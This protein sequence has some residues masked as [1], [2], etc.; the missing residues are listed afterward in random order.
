MGDLAGRVTGVEAKTG[1]V[2]AA[3][4]AGKAGALVLAIPVILQILSEFK[5]SL[6][7]PIQQFVQLFQ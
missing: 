6:V 5:P 1:I 2:P 4:K 7:G 3:K